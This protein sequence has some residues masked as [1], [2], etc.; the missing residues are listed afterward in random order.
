M[1]AGYAE[2]MEP[3][4]ANVPLLIVMLGLT[5]PVAVIGMRIAEKVMKKQAALLK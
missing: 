3:V 5:I 4:I 2:A 1:P